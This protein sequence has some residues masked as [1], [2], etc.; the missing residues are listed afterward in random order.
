[1]RGPVTPIQTSA[2]GSARVLYQRVLLVQASNWAIRALRCRGEDETELR[3]G[4]LES[5]G[6]GFGFGFGSGGNDDDSDKVR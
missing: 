1:M 3:E 6:F 4:K 5:V 2:T